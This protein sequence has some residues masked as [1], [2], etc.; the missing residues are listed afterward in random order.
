WEKRLVALK[1]VVIV[2]DGMAD[3]PLDELGG[4]TPLQIARKPNMD[5]VACRGKCG[6]LK[7]IPEGLPAGSD[8]AILSILGYDPEKYYTGRGPIEAAAL[9][10]ELRDGDVAFRCNLVTL[11]GGVMADYSAGHISSGEARELI[12]ALNEEIG[13]GSVRF[14]SGVSYRNILVISGERFEGLECTPPHDITGMRV[15]E[16]LPR[17]E[18]SELLLELMRAA[19]RVLEEHP[20]NVRRVREG[21]RPANSI[22]PW[23]YGVKPRLQRF[24]ERFGVRGAIISA[25][26][27]VRGLGVLTGLRVVNVPGATGYY[28][29]NYAGKGEYALKALEDVDFVLVHVEAPDEAGHAGDI[30][31]KVKAIERIDSEILGRVLREIDTISSDYRVAVLADHPTPIVKRT[32]TRDPSPVAVLSSNED[33]DEVEGFDEFSVRRGSLGLIRGHDFMSRFIGR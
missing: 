14:Y 22:W 2:G 29:T 10:V 7:A 15:E 1:Y 33:G 20:V 8:V 30:E 12:N 25:V 5:M 28:D 19:Q 3:Y 32:H 11:E 31:N 21:K 24:E 27:L 4:K 16:Y 18:G 13:S 9:G 26:D 6:L 23:G 17:G